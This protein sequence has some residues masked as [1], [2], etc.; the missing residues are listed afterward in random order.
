MFLLDTDHLGILKRRSGDEFD[1]LLERI[2]QKDQQDFY[3]SIISFHEQVRGWTAYLNKRSDSA[4][5]IQG[6]RQLENLISDYAQGQV[7]P[8]GESADEVF[9]EFKQKKI[10]VGT[11][12][13]RIGATAIA[14]GMTVLTRNTVD[15]ERIPDLQFEDWTTAS[16]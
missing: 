15:F 16:A 5:L 4:G 12:D 11:M 8:Y 13:L 6:Y 10:R 14:N 1:R 7:L 2:A 3:I 9:R